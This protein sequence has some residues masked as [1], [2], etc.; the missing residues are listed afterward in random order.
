MEISQYFVLGVMS[1]TSLDG[2]DLAYIQFIKEEGWNFKIIAAETLDY[3]QEWK[4]KLS[5]AIHYD[6]TRLKEFDKK[7]TV[8]LSSKINGFIEKHNIGKL[9][10]ICSHG[11]TIKHQPENGITIQIG[12]LPEIANLTGKKVVCDF[13]IQDVALGGQGAPLVPVGD[14]LLFSQYKYCLNLGG[15]AN[16]STNS[17][18]SWIAY[19]ICPVNTVLNYYAHKLG[20]EFDAEGKIAASGIL[21]EDLLK[22]L[23]LKE[24]Y[25]R[26]PPKSLGME[27]VNSEIFPLLKK[28]EGDIP[29]ILNTFTIHAAT[30]IARNIGDDPFSEV[31]I[32]GGGTFNTFLIQEIK[33]RTNTKI[34]IPPAEIVNY[35]EALIFGFLG[36]LKI[37]NEINVLSSVTGAKRNHS[38][39]KIFLPEN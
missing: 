17:N 10:A 16:V 33:K 35:K 25:H 21:I 15:F 7:Y 32:T 34:F 29:G 13:R 31:I 6:E 11:H 19:D 22:E 37:R 8:L 23:D 26:S 27:W 14:E 3:D 39:G 2:I 5:E 18:N 9:D 36:V 1:G 38:S 12:N 20:F 28:Y 4:M 30:Q 24:F